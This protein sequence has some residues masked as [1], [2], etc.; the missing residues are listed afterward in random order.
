[1]GKSAELHGRVAI[2]IKKRL[3][4]E[5]NLESRVDPDGSIHFVTPIFESNALPLD[6]VSHVMRI[7]GR[8]RVWPLETRAEG[9]RGRRHFH[10]V[11]VLIHSI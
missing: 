4:R 10:L 9:V 6:S 8:S 7:V 2:S 3:I 5:G 11:I 1:M